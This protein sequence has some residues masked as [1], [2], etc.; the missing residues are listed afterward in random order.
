[1]DFKDRTTEWIHKPKFS[2]APE[3]DRNEYYRGLLNDFRKEHKQLDNFLL[4]LDELLKAE[5]NEGYSNIVKSLTEKR[6]G[7]GLHLRIQSSTLL[8]DYIIGAYP[9]IRHMNT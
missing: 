1:M 9:L 4:G 7:H 2:E 8:S 5:K 6:N 3:S